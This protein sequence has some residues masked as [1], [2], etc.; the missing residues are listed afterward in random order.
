[1]Q[2]PS[3]MLVPMALPSPAPRGSSQPGP[4]SAPRPGKDVPHRCSGHF[5]AVAQIRG[6][7]FFFKGNPLGVQRWRTEE[8]SPPWAPGQPPAAPPPVSPQASTSG[9]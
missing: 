5:D 3:G 2:G 4:L 9:G 6:E 8:Q 7:A 1:M